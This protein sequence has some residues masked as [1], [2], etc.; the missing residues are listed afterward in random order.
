M[1]GIRDAGGAVVEGPQRRRV[2]AVEAALEELDRR[3]G[4][5]SEAGPVPALSPAELARLEE[6]WDRIEPVE[7]TPEQRA[8]FEASAERGLAARRHELLRA[9]AEALVDEL[10]DAAPIVLSPDR[11]E[12]RISELVRVLVEEGR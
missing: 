10:E 3:P 7:L 11:L 1:K 12:A 5:L 2:L 9:A 6:V 8:R 4:V